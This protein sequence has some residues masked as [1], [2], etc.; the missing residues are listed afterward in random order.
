M[1]LLFVGI[2][3][4]GLTAAVS[5]G[6]II[7]GLLLAGL[8]LGLFSSANNSAI[9]GSVPMHRQGIA[10]GVVSTA[11]Q[12]GMMLGVAASTTVFRMRYPLYVTLGEA[13][14]TAAA[15]QDTFLAVAVVIAC[16]VLT[17]LVC[18]APAEAAPNAAR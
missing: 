1:A 4:L 16:G 18:G 7:P 5:A 14:A 8:G 10:S 6:E 9:M 17:S 11:R 15:V 2:L 12:L 13:S 3:I